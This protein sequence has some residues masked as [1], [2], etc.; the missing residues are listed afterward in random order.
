M[1]TLYKLRKGESTGS[2]EGSVKRVNSGK[3]DAEIMEAQYWISSRFERGVISLDPF[4]TYSIGDTVTLETSVCSLT[5]NRA[6][7]NAPSLSAGKFSLLL[8][9]TKNGDPGAASGFGR[10]G[11]PAE[12]S[13]LEIRGNSTSGRDY[14]ANGI[15]AHSDTNGSS[16]LCALRNVRVNNF[17]TTMSIGSRAYFLRGYNVSMGGAKFVLLQEAG[18]TDYSENVAFFGGSFFNSDCLVK[19]LAGQQLRLFGVSLDYFGDKTGARVTSDDRLLDI[20]AGGLL[21]L[22]SCHL[23]F[24]Y[25]NNA[26]QTNS[27]IRLTGA[28][29]RLVMHG[30]FFG[31]LNTTQQPLYETPISTDN[32]SQHVVLRD[33]R[34]SYMG[35]K[36]QPTKD[37]QLVGGSVADN[38]SGAI[39]R[40]SVDNLIPQNYSK[41]DI[42]S[43]I[44]YVSGPSLLR[45]GVDAPHTELNIRT[46]V[47]GTAAIASTTTTDGAVTARNSTGAMMKITG[48][49][50]VNITLTSLRVDRRTAWALFLN[51]SQAVG[52]VTVKQRDSTVAQKWDGASALTAVQD[53][54]NAYSSATKSITC[55][56]ANQFERVSWKD[57]HS[58]PAWSPRMGS[59]S[60]F[61]IEIDT[62]AM[63]S[64]A[65]YLDDIAIGQ[66]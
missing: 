63:T 16:V 42:P 59:G 23:E 40:V 53:T 30:G 4:G 41:D 57:V 58:D 1:A 46:S 60:V 43:V 3:G 11:A 17:G 54:R 50:K 27:P 55:G 2:P 61:A 48:A 6:I 38:A 19:T 31:S 5:G 49:G 47:T 21:E 65:I 9:N 39:A 24:D 35:R 20:Q 52:T 14:V 34:L 33:V 51:T 28:N 12:V 37:D 10:Y 26:G 56:G 66:M 8:T 36:N 64:G 45:N 15:R 29:S 7:W 25:G 22:F 18:A 32:S 44:S 13:N 62:S